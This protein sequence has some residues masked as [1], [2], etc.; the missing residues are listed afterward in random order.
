[1]RLYWMMCPPFQGLVSPGPVFFPIRWCCFPAYIRLCWMVYLP[2]RDLI[3]KLFAIVPICMPVLDGT[4]PASRILVSL[5][6][7]SYLSL[8]PDISTHLPLFPVISPRCLQLVRIISLHVP[9]LDGPFFRSLYFYN[10][11]LSP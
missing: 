11:L 3:S 9:V 6:C 7:P 2:S 1:M 5:C 8:F 4:C 10:L